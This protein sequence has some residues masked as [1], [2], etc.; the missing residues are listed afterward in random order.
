MERLAGVDGE[1]VIEAHGSFAKNH[2]IDCHA[3]VS[4]EELQRQMYRLGE[5]EQAGEV[6]DEA[7]SGDEQISVPFELKPGQKIGIPQC[8]NPYCA[9]EG[10]GLVKPDIVFLVKGFLKSF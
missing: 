9:V 1:K 6:K 3:E 5:K 2:C 7:D 10:G 4:T 8:N